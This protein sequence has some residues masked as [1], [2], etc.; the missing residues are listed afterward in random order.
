MEEDKIETND[1]IE[2]VADQLDEA[3]F[4]LGNEYYYEVYEYAKAIES[5]RSVLENVEDDDI[6]RIKSLYRMGESYVKLNQ[7][8]KAIETF[9]QLIEGFEDHYLTSSAQR[10]IERLKEIYG[11]QEEDEQNN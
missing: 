8:D 6:V 9:S 1:E 2:L 11:G 4:F 3:N 7:I 10:R 5:Y